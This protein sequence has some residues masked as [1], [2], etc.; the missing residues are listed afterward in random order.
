[1]SDQSTGDHD[2][3]HHTISEQKFRESVRK[4]QTYILEKIL[5]PA[6]DDKELHYAL[7]CRKG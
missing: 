6:L 7:L 2:F 4:E 5:L 1:M 3:Q